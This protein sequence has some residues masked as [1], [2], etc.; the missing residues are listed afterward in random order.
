M[1]DSHQHEDLQRLEQMEDAS[2][3]MD[4]INEYVIES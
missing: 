4:T 3:R 1:R 2:Y